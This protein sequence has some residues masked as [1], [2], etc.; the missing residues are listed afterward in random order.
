M[1][2]TRDLPEGATQDQ[3][4]RTIAHVRAHL[5]AVADADDDPDT[6]ADDVTVHTEHRDG[7]IRIVGDLDAEPDAPYLKPGFDPYEGV[8]DELR[9]L[10]V[11]D[12][13]GDER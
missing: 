4:D 7:R 6:N 12:E 3:I 11:D 1:K 9:A 13:V 2:Y 10:A 5:S 8:S